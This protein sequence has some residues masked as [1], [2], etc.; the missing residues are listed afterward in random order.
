MAQDS[1]SR[2]L[3]KVIVRLPDGMRDRIKSAAATN[4]RSMNAEIVAALEQ[5]YPDPQQLAEE[6]SFID[7]IDRIQEQLKRIQI[8]QMAAE[9]KRGRE[10]LE[11]LDVKI[12]KADALL[13]RTPKG[14]K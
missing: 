5:A 10:Q 7:E 9:R 3:D 12:E 2:N 11:E 13:G 8:A 6:L 14:K 4:N 1:D